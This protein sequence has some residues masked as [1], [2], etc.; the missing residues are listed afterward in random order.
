MSIHRLSRNWFTKLVLEG[1]SVVIP[2]TKFLVDHSS[3][4]EYLAPEAKAHA[5]H[6]TINHD[7]LLR[8]LELY[9]V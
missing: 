9:G 7:I 4:I 1:V 3:I 5:A 8:K 6:D 2:V